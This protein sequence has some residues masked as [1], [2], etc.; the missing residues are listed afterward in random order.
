MKLLLF[1]VF[2]NFHCLQ[3]KTTKFLCVKIYLD[4]INCRFCVDMIIILM[5]L[6]GRRTTPL[7]ALVSALREIQT[8]ISPDLRE[9]KFWQK[10]KQISAHLKLHIFPTW[11]QIFIWRSVRQRAW[12]ISILRLRVRY[13]GGVDGVTIGLEANHNTHEN[14]ALKSKSSLTISIININ[15]WRWNLCYRLKWNSFS[16]SRV[17]YLVYV[18]RPRFRSKR[19]ISRYFFASFHLF[20]VLGV[21]H[22]R[23]LYLVTSNNCLF[24]TIHQLTN[25]SPSS[26]ST[27]RL[28]IDE[29]T[30]LRSH[31]GVEGAWYRGTLRASRGY[32]AWLGEG[33]FAIW[34]KVWLSTVIMSIYLTS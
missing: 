25:R 3:T 10:M 17:W 27:D 28:T 24:T 5:R 31:P 21:L 11:N 16:S 8:F 33:T 14:A 34:F 7:C 6:L 4:N 9:K 30:E 12:A 22:D 15:R 20:S 2:S 18:C 23:V 13:L 29:L 32:W 26:S 1:L 19:E